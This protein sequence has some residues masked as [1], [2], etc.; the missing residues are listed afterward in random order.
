MD[1]KVLVELMSQKSVL[2]RMRDSLQDL[3]EEN[4]AEQ[5]NYEE[6]L[7]DNAGKE[8]V[9]TENGRIF[10]FLGDLRKQQIVKGQELNAVLFSIRLV[11]EK[12][13]SVKERQ[14]V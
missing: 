6:Q 14:G 11:D 9:T 7:K 8:Q 10:N 12:I 5:C 1:D 4:Y 3:L 13:L 2:C